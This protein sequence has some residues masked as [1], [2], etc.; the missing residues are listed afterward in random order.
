MELRQVSSNQSES[1]QHITQASVEQD[2]CQKSEYDLVA[3]QAFAQDLF[4]SSTSGFQPLIEEGLYQQPET[5]LIPVWY[6][7]QRC[8]LSGPYTFQ[9]EKCI[10]PAC[11]HTRCAYCP[12]DAIEVTRCVSVNISVQDSRLRRAYIAK[13]LMLTWS[14]N[15]RSPKIQL[16]IIG[17]HLADS[18]GLENDILSHT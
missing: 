8:D 10:T 4:S 17:Q 12:R 5:T 18:I 13:Y 1:S 14:S 11:Q 6:C 3:A 9:Y 7:C 15:V 16:Y 2:D